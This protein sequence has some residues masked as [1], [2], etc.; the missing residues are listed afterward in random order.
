MIR[1]M[2]MATLLLNWLQLTYSSDLSPSS[3]PNQSLRNC[4]LLA[5]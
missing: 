4:R 5:P 3:L 2:P 1:L